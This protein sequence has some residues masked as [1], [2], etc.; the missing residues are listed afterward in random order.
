MKKEEDRSQYF[1]EH[2]SDDN[3]KTTRWMWD[4][5]ESRIC[6]WCESREDV[7]KKL[8]LQPHQ[9][10]MKRCRHCKQVKR[11]PKIMSGPRKDKIEL[12]CRE[13]VILP[14]VR[15]SPEGYQRYLRCLRGEEK[16]FPEEEDK[17]LEERKR[18]WLQSKR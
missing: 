14:E 15:L 1:C 17:Y 7:V 6:K 8:N 3:V 9:D 13:C 10:D 2:C 5:I 11:I 16:L 4:G 18:K 12:Y